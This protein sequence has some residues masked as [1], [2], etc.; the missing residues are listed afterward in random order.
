[1]KEAGHTEVDPDRIA[2]LI[3]GFL[4]GTLTTGEQDELDQWVD[5]SDDN[6]RLFEELTDEDKLEQAQAFFARKQARKQQRY[7][8]VRKRIGFGVNR[9]LYLAAAVVTG[10]TVLITWWAL[11][12]SKTER[13]SLAHQETTTPAA[14]RGV[15]LTLANGKI[16]RL[17]S[18]STAPAVPH[19]EV[20]HGTL[21]Y[22]TGGN[23]IGGF[24]TVTVPQGYQ[25]KIVLPDGTAA[26]L[27]CESSLTYPLSFGRERKVQLKGEG[28]F[29]VTKDA[30]RPFVVISE[31]QS[32]TVLG[33]HFNVNCYG[34]AADKTTLL[35]GKVKVDKGL[36]TATLAPGEQAVAGAAGIRVQQVD[37]EEQVAWTKG[38]FLFRNASIESIAAQMKRWYGVEIAYT[39][40]VTQHFNATVSRQE[41]LQ[42]LLRVL[43]GTGFVHFSL[44]G[45]KLVIQP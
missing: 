6:L 33:T 13:R 20:Q 41:S 9:W 11:P 17:D 4:R 5:A 38:L 44:Q 28:Y 29:E 21:Q 18:N 35:E 39:G 34:D 19:A 30:A 8:T 43:E 27:N 16:V 32:V 22:E 2:Y 3:A 45:N 23:A 1:M 10:L 12:G 14:T 26:W 42:R 31:G 36:F 24:N 40:G 25:Y 37:T 15:Q 7:A